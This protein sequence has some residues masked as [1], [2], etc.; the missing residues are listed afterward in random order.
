MRQNIVSGERVLAYRA[1]AL[2]GVILG[3]RFP[4]TVVHAW[5][6]GSP[7]QERTRRSI[8]PSKTRSTT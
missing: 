4:R 1:E 8:E 5:M 7:G 3:A 6:L 2:P